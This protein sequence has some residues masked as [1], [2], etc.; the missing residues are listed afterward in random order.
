MLINLNGHTWLLAIT[1]DSAKL[2]D[3]HFPEKTK[4]KD[5]NK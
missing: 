2:K 5:M 4:D 1:L 3:K